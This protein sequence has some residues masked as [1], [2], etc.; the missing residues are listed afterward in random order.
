MEWILWLIGIG[1]LA[2]SGLM[3]YYRFRAVINICGIGLAKDYEEKKKIK[4][5]GGGA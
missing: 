3:G 4:R 1:I 2:Y 5:L